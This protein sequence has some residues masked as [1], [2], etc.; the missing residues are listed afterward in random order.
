MKESA[1]VGSSGKEISSSGYKP[2]SWYPITV[3]TILYYM[4][5]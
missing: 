5:N 1:I 3:P 4:F 2:E